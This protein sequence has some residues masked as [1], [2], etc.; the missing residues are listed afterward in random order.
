MDSN[1]EETPIGVVSGASTVICVWAL[2]DYWVRFG[3]RHVNGVSVR[4]SFQVNFRDSLASFQ[5]AIVVS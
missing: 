2:A 4:Y 3:D 5:F 1:K